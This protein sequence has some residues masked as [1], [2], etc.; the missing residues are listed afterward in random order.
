MKCTTRANS[1]DFFFLE[2]SHM[3]CCSAVGE[4]FKALVIGKAA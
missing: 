2:I 3:L 4:K 1:H